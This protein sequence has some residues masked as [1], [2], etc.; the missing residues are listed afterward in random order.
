M[1]FNHFFRDL[2]RRCGISGEEQIVF[3]EDKF[4]LMSPRGLAILIHLGYDEGKLSVLEGGIEGW[5]AHKYQLQQT[6][7]L[8]AEGCFTPQPLEGFFVDY[9]EMVS[10]L[11]NDQVIK[12]DVRDEDEW[13]G[14]SSSPYGRDFAPGKGHLPNTL[15]IEWLDFL[16][17]DLMYLRSDTEIESIMAK[18]N[19]TTKDEIVIFCFKGARASNTYIALRKLG[20]TPRIYFAGWNEWCRIPDAPSVVEADSCSELNYQQLLKKYEALSTAFDQQKT[21]LEQQRLLNTQLIDFPKYNRLPIYSF[22]REGT[23]Y[24]ENDAKK[25]LLPKIKKNL[26]GQNSV[27]RPCIRS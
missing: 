17:E 3:Y 11:D 26:P 2:L 4:T 24:F 18:H 9:S 5:K 7:N 22:S 16:T 13:L 6:V 23:V 15:W 14:Y 19:I 1:T 12:I 20:Y 25:Q 27:V 10:L 21:V 8:P